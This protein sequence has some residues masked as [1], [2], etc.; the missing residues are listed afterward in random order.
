[1]LKRYHNIILLV[2]L[3]LGFISLGLPD[4]ALDVAWP[5]MRQIFAQPLDNAGIIV[6][7]TSILTAISGFVSGWFMRRYAV[8]TILITSCLLTVLGLVGYGLS[9]GWYWLLAATLP[10]GLGAGSIDASLNNYVAQHYSSRQMNWLHGCWGLGATFG[11]AIMT[12]ALTKQHNWREGY[13]IIAGIQAFLLI[14]FFLTIPLWKKFKGETPKVRTQTEL[15]RRGQTLGIGLFFM[16]SALETCIGLWFYSM[17]VE[18]YHFST[19]KAGSLIV[20]YWACI[21]G[22]RFAIGIISNFYGNRKIITISLLTTICG[23]FFL[24][25]SSYAIVFIGLALVG[26]SLSGIYPAMMHETPRRFG[27]EAALVLTGYQAGAASLGVAFLT[28]AVGKIIAVT[29]FFWLLP[30]LM[31]MCVIMLLMHLELNR[32]T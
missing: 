1:M 27:S 12:F 26:F 6:F 22:G 5:T 18:V 9:P 17:M 16:Y 21:T 31:L 20:T 19:T 15:S 7:M 2:V 13:M 32:R 25:S 23:L 24:Y 11:P 3:Y 30:L 14:V 4:K 28:P 8:V 10:L 29:S